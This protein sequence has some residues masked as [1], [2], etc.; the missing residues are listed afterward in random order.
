[1]TASGE[2]KSAL[3]LRDLYYALVTQDDSSAY[4]AGTPA[5]VAPLITAN[6]APASNSKTQYAD[7]GPYDVMTA[8]GETKIDLETTAIPI[9]I[10]AILLG[11]TYDASTGRMFDNGGTPPDVAISFR[12]I[13]SNGKYRYFQFLKGKFSAPAEDQAT[14][15]DTPDPKALKIT[16]TAVKTVRQFTLPG[17]ITDGVKV[18]KGDEDATNFSG[19]TWFSSVQVPVVGSPASFTCTPSPADGATG[20]SAS[21]APT[22]TFSNALASY[23]EN[24]IVLVRVST[25]LP[26]TVTRTIN[27]ARTVVT[28]TPGSALTSAAQYLIVVPNPTSIYGQ[29]LGNQVYDFTVA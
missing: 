24:G 17:S 1:M 22:L 21:V 13:K 26:I 28:L 9:E 3:G 25:G 2:Y 15:T 18:V 14:K 27:A 5:Y 23:Q 20:V 8:E 19:T 29:S 4:A 12:S 11:K 16:Y 7:D 10:Q 6:H